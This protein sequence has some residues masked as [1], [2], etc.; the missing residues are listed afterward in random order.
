MKYLPILLL[1]LIFGWGSKI[2]I[3]QSTSQEWVG[4]LQESGYGTD[5]MLTIKV[6]AGSDQLQI[7]DLWVG[8]IH[9]KVRV[10]ADPANLQN[11]TFKKGSRIQV[12]A[13]M[14]FRPGPDEKVGLQDRDDVKKPFN[15]KGEGL[16]AYTYKGKKA[17]LQITGFK[18]LEKIIYP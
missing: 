6:K 2:Q 12:R 5:Y 15:Y 4:G 8:E 3:L 7:E 18:K 17:Y 13:G 16:L 14:T 11:K 1:S 9:R 10:I